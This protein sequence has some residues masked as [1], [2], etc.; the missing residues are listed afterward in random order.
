MD[1]HGLALAFQGDGYL[2]AALG[3]ARRAVSVNPQAIDAQLTLGDLCERTGYARDAIAAFEAAH[4]LAPLDATVLRRLSAAYRR[5]GRPTDALASAHAA[6]E[7]EPEAAATSVCLGDALLAGGAAAAADRLYARALVLDPR[8]ARAECG[9]GAVLLA[10]TRWSDARLAFERALAIDPQCAEARYQR[11]LLDLR[12]GDYRAGFA[13]YPA[14]VDTEEQRPR[15]H[16]Y[17]AGVPLWDGTPLDGRRL[18]VAYEMGLGNQLMMARFFPALT[19]F[20]S[21]ITIETPPTL[22]ALFRRNLPDLTFSEFTNW[23]PTENMD[24]HLPLMQ[25]P[26]V[27]KVARA[28]DIAT[29]GPYLTAD[30]ARVETLRRR[31]NLEP[32]VRH[33]GVVWHGNRANARD[34]WR[35][36]PLPAW[37]PLAAVPGLRF[38]SLQLGAT[39]AELT[40]APFALAPAHDLI[41]DMEDTAA[42][43]T[44]M[45]FIITVDTSIVHLAGALGRPVWMPQPLRSD[46]RWGVDR[47]DSPWYPSLHII[48]QRTQDDWQP[49]FREIAAQL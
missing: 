40:A 46:Y 43:V 45:E 2:T 28:A 14:I 23:Q 38:H 33:V 4:R 32:G 8:L 25:L 26:S 49:A 31:L 27:L 29:P 37:S 17:H 41:G 48:R 21:T 10:E 20:G 7:L 19:R 1:W 24:V 42:L 16:Y 6:A 47:S 18:V 12:F 35:A 30:P 13:A 34:R 3:A 5:G 44:L 15:Y 11:A 22:L 36:A 39:P 9:R